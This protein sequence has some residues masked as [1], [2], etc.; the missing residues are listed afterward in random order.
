MTGRILADLGAD[1]VKVEPAEGDIIRRLHP[2]VGDD[3]VSVYFTWANAGK[4]SL[5]IDLRNRQGAELV[6]QLAVTSDVLLDNFRPGVLAK[7]GLDAESLLAHMGNQTVP[8]AIEADLWP[9][10]IVLAAVTL[11]GV[12][13][14]T[15]LLSRQDVA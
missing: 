9:S 7:F 8:G 10:V 15:I 2:Q 6:R 12:A 5:T 11:A 3:P 14:T 4:R 13:L 1:V